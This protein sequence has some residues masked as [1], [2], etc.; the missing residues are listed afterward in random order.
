MDL[1]GRYT[2][3]FMY[4]LAG[5]GIKGLSFSAARSE[6]GGMEPVTAKIAEV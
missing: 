1:S 2:L 6:G 5:P 3:A 4:I